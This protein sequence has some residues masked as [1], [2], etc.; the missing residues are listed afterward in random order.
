MDVSTREMMRVG[1]YGQAVWS[2]PLDA[3]VKSIEMIDRRRWLSSPIHRGEYG[4]AEKNHRAGSAGSFGFTCGDYA[5]GLPTLYLPT[6]LRVRPAPGIPCA[7]RFPRDDVDA[8]LGHIRV[9][10]RL[11][12]VP[13]MQRSASCGALLIR[14]P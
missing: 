2:C 11:S 8:K 1:A 7:L 6:R 3:G 10:G 12:L 4:A 5:C 9:A 14:G 13:R